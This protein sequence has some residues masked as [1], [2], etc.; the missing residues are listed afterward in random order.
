MKKLNKDRQQFFSDLLD[1][2][3]LEMRE[4]VEIQ[5]TF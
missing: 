1:G 4:Y 5:E 3:K 2:L